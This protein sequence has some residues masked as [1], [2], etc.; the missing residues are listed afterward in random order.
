MA[1]PQNQTDLV[2]FN[3]GTYDANWF[4]CVINNDAGRKWVE[5]LRKKNPKYYIK[6]R[7]RH[8]NRRTAY[9]NMGRDYDRCYREHIIPLKYSDRFVV[10]MEP[11][12]SK[13]QYN[14]CKTCGAKDGRA[15]MLV[16]GECQ[17][18]YDTR[19]TGSFVIHSFL[20]RTAVELNRMAIKILGANNK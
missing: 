4:A 1:L 10:Y 5:T 19:K 3:N 13:M 11:K 15:G 18:C 6:C 12:K 14:V 17:N 20:N 9:E 7:G 8:S 16:N 2:V